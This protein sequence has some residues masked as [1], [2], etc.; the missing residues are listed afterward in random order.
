[1]KE[2]TWPLKKKKKKSGLKVIYLV[3]Q[4]VEH[5]WA[6]VSSNPSTEKKKVTYLL[7]LESN[8]GC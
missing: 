2:E 6:S 5:L 8:P 1:L 3:A 4:M 7:V